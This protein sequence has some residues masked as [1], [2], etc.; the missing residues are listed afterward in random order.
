M[1]PAFT[2]LHDQ[3]LIEPIRDL[4]RFDRK[5]GSLFLPNN[6]KRQKGEH[7]W[8]GRVVAV[9]PGDKTVHLGMAKGQPSGWHRNLN[10]DGS[11][12]ACAVKPGDRVIYWRR[13][14]AEVKFEG[15]D[16]EYNV[17]LEEQHIAAVIEE[18]G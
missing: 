2:P 17:V 4:E 16:K 7:L 18:E 15:D 10:P 1:T 13:L 12:Q 9:G 5:V 11:A 6:P 8:E 14:G 3:V